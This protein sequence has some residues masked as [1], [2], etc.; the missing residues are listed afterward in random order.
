MNK[1]D[2]INASVNR[3]NASVIGPALEKESREIK[4]AKMQTNPR[5]VFTDPDDF[6]GRSFLEDLWLEQRE[7]M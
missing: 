5:L 7:Q 6:F 2:R 1:V 4:P 3:I